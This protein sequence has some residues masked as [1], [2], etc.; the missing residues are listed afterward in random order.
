MRWP[1]SDRPTIR[2]LIN[3][4]IIS[5]RFSDRISLIAKFEIPNSHPPSPFPS[6]SLSAAPLPP[7][8]FS[9]HHHHHCEPPIPIALLLSSPLSLSSPLLSF[10]LQLHHPTL[11]RATCEI[12]PYVV[13][14]VVGIWLILPS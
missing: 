8:P 9:L 3:N 6:S 4:F 13:A 14:G 5:D 11:S 1:V 2:S 10:A 7:N 12:R